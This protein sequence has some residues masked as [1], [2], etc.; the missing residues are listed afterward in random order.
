MNDDTT[1]VRVSL[2]IN[3]NDPDAVHD[4]EPI[5]F[6]G[7][8]VLP[9]EGDRVHIE[10]SNYDASPEGAQRVAMLL[11]VAAQGIRDELG[12]EQLHKKP[13]R[14]TFNPRPAGGR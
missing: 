7:V 14:P 5:Q 10:A 2:S 6:I 3:S 1:S 11:E 4:G 13:K 9:G 12:G 8:A